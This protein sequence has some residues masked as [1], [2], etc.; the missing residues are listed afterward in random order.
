MEKKSTKISLEMQFKNSNIDSYSKSQLV[1]MVNSTSGEP[2]F[3]NA[4]PEATF[5]RNLTIKYLEKKYDMDF[6]GRSYVL[7]HGV[8]IY[9]L[10]EIYENHNSTQMES[11]ESPIRSN[12]E[13]VVDI[14]CIPVGEIKKKKSL[15]MRN[16][17]MKRWEEFLEEYQNKS[18]YLTAACELFMKRFKEGKVKMEADWGSTKF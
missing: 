17:T 16:S 4:F 15:S 3:S 1:Y 2:D 18:D 10:L 9:K 13:S 5:G 7:P 6:I 12:T 14:V 11:K 8:T